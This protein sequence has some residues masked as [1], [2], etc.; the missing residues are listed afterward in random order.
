MVR[1][2]G[3]QEKEIVWI[4]SSYEDF[5]AFPITAKRD[6][7]YQLHRIQNDLPP[8]NF[9][10]YSE[11]GAGVCELRLREAT[12]IFR[13]MY[14]AKFDEAIYVLHCFQKK[15]Q[16]TSGSDKEVTSIR[17]KAVWRYRRSPK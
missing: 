1:R 6:A 15:T 10:S 7:G 16:R 9:K 2:D 14:V 5:F 13:V 4:G 11:L 12:G 3:A 17:Y 8:E